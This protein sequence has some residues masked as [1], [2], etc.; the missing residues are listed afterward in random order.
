MMLFVLCLH[1][2]DARLVGGELVLGVARVGDDDD[3]VAALHE[4][5]GGAVDRHHARAPLA[6]DRVRLKARAVV[7]V[8]HVNLLVLEDVGGLE[9]VGVDRDRPDVVQVAVSD[10]R[11]VDLRLEH[12]SLHHAS[13]FLGSG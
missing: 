10:R 7:D 13:A 3:R 4:P 9:Q 8:E 12:R 6:R 1:V 2:H 5:G 11:P